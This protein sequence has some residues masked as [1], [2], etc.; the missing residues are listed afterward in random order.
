MKEEELEQEQS[1]SG[2]NGLDNGTDLAAAIIEL[3]KNTVSR[4]AY[5]KLEG[6]NKKLVK[7]LIDGEQLELPNKEPFDIVAARKELYG[8]PEADFT[9]L[10]YVT[11]VM[12]LRDAII[13]QGGADP[14][15]PSGRGIVVTADD[16]EQAELAAQT[17]RDCIEYAQ[18]D[19][20]AFT[21]ELM[22]RTQDV[23]V[24]QKAKQNS[25]YRR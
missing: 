14:F 12:A 16:R 20:Q 1:E 23:G 19:S 7:A 17:F 18:G 2:E 6:E 21:N 15:L 10:D 24:V 3:K 9:N 25:Y 5:E 8:N 11:K 22:R 13:E 4:S